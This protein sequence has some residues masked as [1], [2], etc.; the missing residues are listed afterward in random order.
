MNIN[1]K[2]KTGNP[3]KIALWLLNLVVQESDRRFVIGDFFEIYRSIE[4]REG[5]RKAY[6]WLWIE[7]LRSLPDFVSNTIYW[8]FAMV[9]NYIKIAV[10]NILKQK[11]YSFINIA[12]LTIGLVCCLLITMWILDELSYDTFHD[13]SE[14]VF[15]I[16]VSE[17]SEGTPNILAPALAEQIPEIEYA[18]RYDWLNTSLV[19]SGSDTS[20]E[21]ITAVDPSFFDV[22][23][24]PFISGD[25]K[26]ALNDISSIVIAE[27]VAERF[28]P[29]GNAIGQF[30]TFDNDKEMQVTGVIENVPHNSTLQFDMLVP[31]EY[32]VQ[33][34]RERDEDYA[35][36]GWWS[37][38]SYVKVREGCTLE[39]LNDKIHDFLRNGAYKKDR[40]LWA[41]PVTDMHAVY[42]NIK[43]YIYSFSIVAAIV[44]FMACINFINLSIARSANRAKETGI[45]KVVGASRVNL[46]GQFLGESLFLI[47]IGLLLAF[48]L[49]DLL[50]PIFNE[51]MGLQLSMNLLLGNSVLPTL[52]GLSLLTGIL[53]GLYPAFYLSAFQPIAVLKGDFKSGPGGSRLRK[54]LLVIQFVASVVL[55]I[56]TITIFTQLDYIRSK[57]VGYYKDQVVHVYMEGDQYNNFRNELLRNHNILSVSGSAAGMPYWRWSTS[58]VDWTGKD[59]NFDANVAMNMVD[60][61][62]TET[63]GIEILQGRPFDRNIV[64]DSVSAYLVNEEMV[65]YMGLETVV[66]AELTIWDNPG[67]IIGVMRNFHFR[68]LTSPIRPLA[69]VIN[70][71]KVGTVAIRI[72]AGEIP[73]AMEYIKETWQKMFPAFPIS[74]AFLD[75]QFDRQY[76]RIERIGNLASGFALLAIFIACLGLFGLS[77]FTAQ[78]RTKE[79]GIRKVLGASM[80]SIVRLLSKEFVIMVII[81]NLIAWPIGWYLMKEWLN[82][83]AYRIELG[84]GIFVIAGISALVIAIATV[85][86]QALVAAMTSPVKTLKS[87]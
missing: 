46:I 23:T 70:Q 71:E 61:G 68:P 79:I 44:L 58:S 7:I 75:E 4:K 73:S 80:I 12:G 42:S 83:F 39:T 6:F 72:A 37:A 43:T 55:I 27:D 38:S 3:P 77:S 78:Q 60:F 21:R 20:F 74:Y 19:T 17:G 9:K 62:F 48:G 49:L 56:G 84:F 31:F 85:S 65:K 18:T 34:H 53:A 5:F 29:D 25:P 45:R 33:F 35:S 1:K 41:I 76:N 32:K 36:W 15:N 30:L 8:R 57:D 86:Y 10:R 54:S 26:T 67:Q 82:E 28:F 13:D 64:S 63:Y 51:K 69:F 47:L 40:D 50:L 11:G 16:L 24:F 87:E 14:L 2:D 52:I 22:F 81:A 66:G 59:P